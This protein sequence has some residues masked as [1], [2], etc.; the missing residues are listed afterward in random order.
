MLNNFHLNGHT[1]GPGCLIERSAIERNR[2]PIVRLCSVIEH[3]RTHKKIWS[4]EHNRTFDYRTVSNRT[5]SNHNG[6]FDYRTT[7]CLFVC[8]YKH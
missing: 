1:L 7:V 4:I 8:R 3:N 6:T 5:Q 2:T